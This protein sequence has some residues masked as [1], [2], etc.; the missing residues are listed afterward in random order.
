MLHAPIPMSAAVIHY[1]R[2][3]RHRPWRGPPLY[4]VET[5]FPPW[6]R[7]NCA[8]AC[9]RRAP[10]ASGGSATRLTAAGVLGSVTTRSP[11][12][13][14]ADLLSGTA[15]M[16]TSPSQRQCLAEA[17][18]PIGQQRP[19]GMQP[20]LAGGTT[21]SAST[22]PSEGADRWDGWPDPRGSAPASPRSRRRGR[23]DAWPPVHRRRRARLALG[24]DAGHQRTHV[25][26]LQARQLHGAE[27]WQ[28]VVLER[29]E[30][31]AHRAGLQ[32]GRGRPHPQVHQIGH[33]PMAR[34]GQAAAPG[35]DLELRQTADGLGPRPGRGV[36]PHR[37]HLQAHGPGAVRPLGSG[38][39]PAAALPRHP[40]APFFSR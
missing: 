38:T 20:V 33:R 27:F 10:T 17:A 30:A 12:M 24:L 35:L 25:G 22:T 34:L 37:T 8:S 5:K 15:A 1:L 2:F 19:K 39:L 7:R 9:G 21:G 16:S 23:S 18:A 3:L 28:E 4:A 14:W 26:G 31:V 40:I 6:P 13:R 29:A 11:R 36:S 32:A